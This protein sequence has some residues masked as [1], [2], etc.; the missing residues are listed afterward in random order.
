MITESLSTSVLKLKVLSD[1][2]IASVSGGMSM[3]DM[4]SEM[5]EAQ[6]MMWQ[7]QQDAQND[8]GYT[9][10][11]SD[12]SVWAEYWSAMYEQYYEQYYRN[13]S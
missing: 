9:D 11:Q 6:Q 4:L 8:P 1:E 7:I 5:E 13:M 3:E 2:E 12:Y 10:W